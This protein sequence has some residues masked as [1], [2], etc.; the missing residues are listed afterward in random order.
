MLTLSINNAYLNRQNVV[1]VYFDEE[2]WEY[3]KIDYLKADV[4]AVVTQFYFYYFAQI[5]YP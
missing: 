2:F 4:V 1:S 5:L 3:C